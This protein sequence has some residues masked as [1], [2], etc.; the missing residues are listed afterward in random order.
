LLADLLI[1]DIK[2]TETAGNYGRF[3][4]EPLE[5]GV[6]VTLGNALRRVLLSS[7]PGAAVTWILIDGIQHEFSCIP[8]LKEDVIE[9][10]L[11]VKELRLKPLSEQPGKKL[12]LD[13]AGEGEICAADITPT[14]DFEI[15][16]PELHL[17][18][19]DSSDA[20]LYVEFNVELGRGYV[21]GKSSEGLP[22]GALPVDAIFTPIHKVNF[23][24]VPI[25]PGEERSSERLI[26]EVWTDNTISPGEA[27]RQSANVLINQFKP[28]MELEV[29]TTE[30]MGSLGKASS[31]PAERYNE[32]IEELNLSV[33]AFNSLRRGGITSIGQLIE[34][35]KDGLPPLPGLGAKSRGEVEAVLANL[36][37]SVPV[38][39][40]KKE[41]E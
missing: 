24:V 39:I 23:S 28:F 8:N 32:P 11:N 22:V 25:S 36:G 38:N 3:I 1:P 10:I 20:K 31:I 35:A 26:L 37:C 2:C 29:A 30:G 41:K 9:F 6:G 7:L 15:A 16:N 21:P 34:I 27:I 13:V 5:K 12:V 18:S 14:I 17:A 4:V 40:E 33:R 19:L